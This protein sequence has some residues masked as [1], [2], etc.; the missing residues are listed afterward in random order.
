MSR[1]VIVVG[2]GV[3]GTACAHELSHAGCRVTVVDQ[4]RHGAA[5]SHANCGYVC[6]SHVLPLTEPGA[7][8]NALKSMFDRNSPFRV[9]PRL[10]F[11]LIK[12]LWNF[13][14]RCN[15]QDMFAAAEGL[16]P[17]LL[18][19]LDLY[20]E[21]IATHQLDCDWEERGLLYV[22]RSRARFAA[23]AKTD[24][25]LRDRYNEPA[26]RVEPDELAAIEPALKPGMAGGWLYEH[27]AHLRSDKLMP[28]WKAMLESRGVT[29]VELEKVEQFLGRDGLASSVRTASGRELAADAFVVAT[30][31]WGPF[32][33]SQ[34]G[35][36]IPIQP[37]KGYSITMPRPNPCPVYPMIFPETRVA[38]TPWAS[39]YRLGSTMEFAG[40]DSS[41]NPRRL[42][43]LRRGSQDYLKEPYC[44]PVQEVWYGWRPMTW[45]GL[46]I[47]DRSPRWENTFIAAGHNMIGL[48]MATGTGRLIRELLLGETPH[49]N[50]AHYNVARFG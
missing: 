35:C 5:C 20:R 28:A 3:I 27:D 19:S 25:L 11:A 31:A 8:G 9:K 29:F 26:R 15:E 2:G 30:G 39:G 33:Q 22:Y 14:R 34:L 41:I 7:I 50:P 21:L 47:I 42:D 38:V 10:D 23:Y 24:T 12:W 40:Y 49:I 46:P 45:D 1:H 48:S 43:L 16:Q 44:E 32:L 17:L 6:P 18:S 37:G 13:A 4:G 36:S